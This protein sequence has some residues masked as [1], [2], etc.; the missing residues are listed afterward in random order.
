M[1]ATSSPRIQRWVGRAALVAP[2]VLM[3]LWGAFLPS[4]GSAKKGKS[5]V[6]AAELNGRSL[7]IQDK[8][9]TD[10]AVRMTSADGTTYVETASSDR[11]GLF[12]FRV[13]EP[14][15]EYTVALE[16]EGYAPFSTTLSLEP[17]DEQ[18][19]DFR[20]ITQEMGQKQRAVEAYNEGVQAFKALDKAKAKVLFTEASSLDSSLAQA[21]F[22]LTDIYLEEEDF[23]AAA[24]AAERYMA[25]AP[26]DPKGKRL[27]YQAYLGLGDVD[28]Q[29][30]MRSALK[31]TDFSDTLAV[32][33][34]N[35]GAIASQ[36]GD[37]DEAVL[38]FQAALELDP[39]LVAAYNG[40]A[41]VYYNQ[42]KYDEALAAVAELLKRD[43]DNLQGRRIRYLIHDVRNDTAELEAAFDA[44][45]EVDPANA[46][47]VLHQRA[48]LDFRSGDSVAALRNLEKVVGLAPDMARAYYTLGLV[49]FSIDAAKAK[50]YLRKFIAMAPDDPEVP[51]AQQMLTSD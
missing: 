50:E 45:A 40:L 39:E 38:Q 47:L 8:V 11:K 3:I 20:L 46:A 42:E 12:T 23:A 5:K 14:S 49:Y 9:L 35:R 51:L 27:A 48:E 21:F 2:L 28:K 37:L 26:D 25:L 30:L 13:P 33:T 22:G 17:G 34:F 36:K 7:D 31:D 43:A 15:G 29:R 4:P 1:R 10:V 16:K 24:E 18:N 41:S 6:V 32:Q 44:Y 19:I